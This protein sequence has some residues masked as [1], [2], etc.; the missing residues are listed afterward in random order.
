MISDRDRR[1]IGVFST[2]LE[3]E[4][5]LD[6][7]SDSGFPMDKVSVIARDADRQDDIAGVYVQEN[8]GNKAEGYG[9]IPHR[10]EYKYGL[11]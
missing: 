9:C 6:V 2:R 5:A 1:A 11:S 3:A 8:V 4:R 10:Y 7:L